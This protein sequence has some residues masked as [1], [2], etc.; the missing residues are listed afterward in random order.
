MSGSRL[1]TGRVQRQVE[2]PGPDHVAAAAHL[3]DHRVG[4]PT[5]V[6]GKAPLTIGARA[7]PAMLR[8]SSVIIASRTPGAW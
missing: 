1:R 5:N 4:L 6:V 7:S 3:L 8:E 2:T